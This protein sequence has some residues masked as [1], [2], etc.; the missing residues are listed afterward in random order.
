MY[1]DIPM[2]FY[3]FFALGQL[4]RSMFH[5]FPPWLD[6]QCSA[7][8]LII[9]ICLVYIRE[10][11]F[12]GNVMNTWLNGDEDSGRASGKPELNALCVY[13]ELLT[14]PAC[15]YWSVIAL[16]FVLYCFSSTLIVPALA[17]CGAPSFPCELHCFVWYV[18]FSGVNWRRLSV[19][20]KRRFCW[21]DAG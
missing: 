21:L 11:V 14:V 9:Y 4:R 19:F 17:G 20:C 8:Q 1:S 18:H 5:F 6:V 16:F 15:P 2:F 7:F 10:N 12:H 13:G 3:V